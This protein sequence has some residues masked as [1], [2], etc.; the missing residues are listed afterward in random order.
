M[1]LKKLRVLLCEL[2]DQFLPDLSQSHE[3]RDRFKEM[4]KIGR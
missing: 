3:L 2:K 1:T 4:D